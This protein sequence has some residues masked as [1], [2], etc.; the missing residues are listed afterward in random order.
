M[1]RL[2]TVFVV[3]ASLGIFLITPASGAI[4]AG[5]SCTKLKATTIVSGYK[6]SCIKSGNRLIWSKGQ[7]TEINAIP[8]ASPKPTTGSTVTVVDKDL[9]QEGSSCNSFGEKI[10]TSY[11]FIRCDWEGGYRIAWHQHRIPILSNSK[12]NNYTVTPVANQACV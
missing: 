11:G 3:S 5:A 7:K 8:A 9:P 12:S 2:I 1:K 6:Y 4:K 10:I